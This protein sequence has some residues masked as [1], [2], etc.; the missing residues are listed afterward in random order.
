MNSRLRK[1]ISI[2]NPTLDCYVRAVRESCGDQADFVRLVW[3]GLNFE[4]PETPRREVLIFRGVEISESALESYRDS[5]GKMIAWSTFSSFTEKREEAE[6][7]GRAWRGG[8]PVL[9]ELRSLLCPRLWNGTYL[10]HPFAV[11]QVEAVVANV[12]KLVEVEL[13]EPAHVTKLPGQR[14]GAVAREGSWT[15]LHKAAK[16]GDVRVISRFASRPEFIDARD[17]DGLTPLQEASYWGKV[18]AVKALLWLGANV[19]ARER[20]VG[21][22]ALF[23]SSQE[24]HHSIVRIL[25]SFGANVNTPMNSGATPVYVA[26]QN[27]HESTV[28]ALASLGADVNTPDG[29]GAT[30]VLVASQDGH[31]ATVRALASLGAD[32]NTPTRDG[33]T[34]AFIASQKGHEA[35]V[36]ALA[37][38]GGNLNTP[39]NDGATPVY[40]ASHFGHESTV[41]ALASLGANVNTPA[42]DGCTP[43]YVAAQ[44]GRDSMVRALALF[45]ANVNTPRKNGGTPLMVAACNGHVAVVTALLKAGASAKA[46]MRD[47]R[48]ALSIAKSKGHTEI[49]ALL[50]KA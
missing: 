31:W 50:E 16:C 8:I 49:I 30:P 24:G 32:V 43:V 1:V 15:E 2:H 34:P 35:T 48:T 14:P 38:A 33:V 13:L 23:L 19:H 26:S 6:E 47:G 7:Y 40:V 29:D 28:R 17:T 25:V 20:R 12:V 42:N 9:F 44:N 22:T 45:G 39:T 41:R 46:V 11:M 18:E 5:V 27:G 3:E 10:Q 36:R 4:F 21:W 37:S